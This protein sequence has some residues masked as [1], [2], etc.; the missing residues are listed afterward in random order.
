MA[1]SA[2]PKN[3]S[4]GMGSSLPHTKSPRFDSAKR[5]Y[6]PVEGSPFRYVASTPSPGSATTLTRTVD[7]PPGRANEAVADIFG[8]PPS[9]DTAAQRGSWLPLASR[10]HTTWLV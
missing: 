4:V 3:C 7:S 6:Q 10:A 2:A 8:F 9:N 5:E 1:T